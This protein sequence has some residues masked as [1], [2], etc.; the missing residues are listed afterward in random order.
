MQKPDKEPLKTGIFFST[1]TSG[2]CLHESLEYTCLF[3]KDTD[4]V[5]GVQLD[6]R[7]LRWTER[8]LLWVYSTIG[9]KP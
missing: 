6:E 8:R 7:C 9:K 3:H 1:E 5:P 2:Q 4:R